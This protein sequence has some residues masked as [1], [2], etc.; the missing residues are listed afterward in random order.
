MTIL[1]DEEKKEA[2]KCYSC[3]WDPQK[4]TTRILGI[5]TS[6]VFCT[7]REEIAEVIANENR[8]CKKE[9]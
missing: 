3:G 9:E 6:M 4:I 2:L 1:T 8:R 5:R 7:V